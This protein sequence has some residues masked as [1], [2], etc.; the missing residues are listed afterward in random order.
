M[1]CLNGLT[2][3]D[4]T[5]SYGSA[6]GS[7][8]LADFEAR[9]IK[10]ELPGIGD[11]M[12]ET[13][14]ARNGA[15]G[16]FAAV[17]R[18]KDSVILDFTK[19]ENADMIRELVKTA[20]IMVDDFA[21]RTLNKIGLTYEELQKSNPGLIYAAVTG[22]GRTEQETMTADNV[23][24]AMSGIQQMTGFPTEEPSKIG[25]AVTE[26]FAGLNCVVGILLAHLHRMETGEGQVVDIS[27]LDSA[28][29]ILE[30]PVLFES[31]FGME[32]KRCGNN[33][34]E[35]L[36][37]YDVYQCLDG[38]FSAG[39][40]GET[41]W[42]RFCKAIEMPE[43]EQDSRFASNELRCKSYEEVTKII[44]PFFLDKTRRELQAIFTG[45]N[46]PNAPVLSVEEVMQHPQLKA[47]EML[48]EIEDKT[49]GTYVAVGNPMKLEKTPAIICRGAP[50]LGS[51]T[52]AVLG[53]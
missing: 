20:D 41:G 5:Q 15:S 27:A 6:F 17:N 9:V 14:P 4:F 22:F 52:D 19:A 38:Y 35:T 48:V 42:D 39:L 25:P 8:Q 24:Q 51:S 30:A 49:V 28:F 47:R 46:I 31:M 23:I 43:L 50:V 21:V 1:G 32:S 16:Y 33:D 12:R 7:M 11:R 10:V 29:G 3:L 53:K 2:V 45:A 34:A 13:R 37:P 40:A 44:S 36:V 26:S 18:G